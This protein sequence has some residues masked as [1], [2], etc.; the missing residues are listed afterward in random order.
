MCSFTGNRAGKFHSFN[1]I[2]I[3]YIS[4]ILIMH[5]CFG[6]GLSFAAIFE[7]CLHPNPC[8]T[9]SSRFLCSI[10]PHFCPCLIFCFVLLSRFFLFPTL[11]IL[12]RLFFFH[13]LLFLQLQFFASPFSSYIWLKLFLPYFLST[14]KKFLNINMSAQPVVYSGEKIKI[15]SNAIV[16]K[17]G[18]MH[19]PPKIAQT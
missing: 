11:H 4:L 13:Q 6:N 7:N 10:W 1:L 19:P 2:I 8:F 16:V 12:F 17:I 15:L 3:L 18:F 14:Y 9:F 5:P